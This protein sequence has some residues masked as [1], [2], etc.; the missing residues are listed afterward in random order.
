MLSGC[1]LPE[2]AKK[3]YPFYYPG[4]IWESEDGLVQINVRVFYDDY[5]HGTV[6]KDGVP[7]EMV[8]AMGIEGFS[9]IEGCSVEDYESME[10]DRYGYKDVTTPTARKLDS[11]EYYHYEEL[12]G[13]E[14][15]FV[16]K[17]E[18][19]SIYEEGELVTFY[20]IDETKEI[21]VKTFELIDYEKKVQKHS[22]DETLLISEQDLET[23]VSQ[24]RLA[25]E[26]EFGTVSDKL[27][28]FYDWSSDCWLIKG[29]H[30]FEPFASVPHIIFQTDGRVLAIWKG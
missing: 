21:T 20:R 13:Q 17:I 29:T 28:F 18:D 9:F 22:S 3:Q 8:F 2:S 16:A 11:H 27:E 30:W 7:V 10:L 14:H 6:K 15:Y 4:S 1:P 26:R 24:A 5:V 23:V 25:L 12:C 19:S